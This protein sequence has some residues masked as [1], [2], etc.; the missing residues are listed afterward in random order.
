[1][2]RKGVN[3]IV[4]DPDE[5]QVLADKSGK[6]VFKPN[7]EEAL[8][9]LIKIQESINQAVE[10]VKQQ[11]LESG[12]S[13]LP[14]FKGIV[15]KKLKIVCVPR[16]AKYTITSAPVANEYLVEHKRY[17]PDSRKIEQYMQEFG[18]P[19][20]GIALQSRSRSVEIRYVQTQTPPEL[21][22]PDNVVVGKT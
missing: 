19:P 10:N 13:V 20:P 18:N 1:M 2:L 21:L 12:D 7:A 16:G 15:G 5:I 17:Y 9:K 4:I 22:S 11:I 14:G 8:E 3:A 6:L